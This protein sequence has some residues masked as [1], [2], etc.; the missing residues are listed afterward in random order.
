MT[1]L[2]PTRARARREEL[3]LTQQELAERVGISR[4]ALLAIESGKA[5][6]SVAIAIRLAREL[7]VSVEALF[8]EAE[9]AS[10]PLR[11]SRVPSG[12]RATAVSVGGRWTLH[13]LSTTEG[14]ARSA[15][16]IVTHGTRSKVTLLDR[17]EALANVAVMGC[18]PALGILCDR[19]TARSPSARGPRSR[20]VW[21]SA[22]SQESLDALARGETHI[23]GVHLVAQDGTPDIHAVQSAA[24]R[25][26]IFTLAHW[27]VGLVVAHANPKRIRGVEDLA[28]S[29][30]RTVVREK[31]SGAR[32][33]L[34]RELRLRKLPIRLAQAGAL[35]ATSHWDVAHAIAFGAADTGWASSDAA[36]AAGLAFI[37]VAHERFDLVVRRSSLDDPRI[38]RLFDELSGANFRREI[39]ATGYDVRST[40]AAVPLVA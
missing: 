9:P 12:P 10:E 31:G 17:E 35:T 22:S 8:A 25:A 33:S 7:G 21:I 32:R 36:E 2:Q 18:A 30:V 6:P 28:R 26:R 19:L 4:Q 11:L 38:V 14:L 37:P 39:E 34:E 5:V 29:D 13:S 40:G 27:N 3:T 23:A 24:A 1:D 16:A 20:F 15:D